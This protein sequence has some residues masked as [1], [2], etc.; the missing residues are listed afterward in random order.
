MMEEQPEGKYL[1]VIVA[2]VKSS[3]RE[4]YPLA[5]NYPMGLLPIGVKRLIVYQL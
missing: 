5:K 1:G 4:L 2:E 3:A